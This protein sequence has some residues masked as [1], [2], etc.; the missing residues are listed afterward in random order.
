VTP[1]N[2]RRLLK[3]ARPGPAVRATALNLSFRANRTTKKLQ[4]KNCPGTI[5]VIFTA[6]PKGMTERRT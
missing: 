6:A 4:R 3:T 5:T 1:R 2:R